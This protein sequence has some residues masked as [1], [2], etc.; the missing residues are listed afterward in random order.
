MPELPEVETTVEGIKKHLLNLTIKDVWTSYGSKY[1][2]GKKNIKDKK[3]FLFFRKQVIGEKII[4]ASRRAKNVLIHLSHGKTMLIHMK[5]TG[6]LLYGTYEKFPI[7][8]HQIPKKT[9]TNNLGKEKEKNLKNKKKEMWIAKEPGPLQDPFNRFIRLLFILS[10][11]KHLAFSDTRKFGKVFVSDTKEISNLPEFRKLGPEPLE[12]TF[13]F[14]NFERALARKPN[15]KIKQVLMNQEIIS[16]IGNI[17]SDEMLWKSDIHPLSTVSKIPINALKNLFLSMKE[18]L[19]K[20]I[21][22]GGDSMSDY[23]NLEGRK[24]EF[25]HIHNAYRLTHKK[26]KKR[27]CPGIIERA[28]IG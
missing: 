28:K 27:G 24:G 20:G 21:N 22:F 25:Q 5:M 3:Y 17:Y 8:N 6:H 19:K 16:G 10:N 11:K 2:L 23:R 12:K 13:L 26:C 9:K 14:K 1:H 4:G 15:G 7:I 18:T